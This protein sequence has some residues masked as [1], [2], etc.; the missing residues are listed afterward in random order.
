MIFV[1]VLDIGQVMFFQAMLMDR[2]RAG[3]RYAVV[4]SYDANVLKN[5]VVFNAA[6]APLGAETGLFG[7][8][9]SM[10]TSNRFDP[11][12]PSDRIEVIIANF[13][14]AFYGPF[15]AA[16]FPNRTFRAVMPS[17]SLGAPQ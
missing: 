5:V 4:N 12:G 9:T 6:V 15:L 11:E 16:T 14:L 3:A 13:P 1:E 17:H 10:V 7:L 8:K 2:V